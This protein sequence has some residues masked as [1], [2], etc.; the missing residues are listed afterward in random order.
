MFPKLSTTHTVAGDLAESSMDGDA[1]DGGQEY[2]VVEVVEVVRADVE[3]LFELAVCASAAE[4]TNAASKR[5]NETTNRR[6][7]C[8][9]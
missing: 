8:I 9:L 1:V 3:P 5:R 2:P 4:G 6:V 7:F